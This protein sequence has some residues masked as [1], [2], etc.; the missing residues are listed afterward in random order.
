MMVDIFFS[1][2]SGVH[3]LAVLRLEIDSNSVILRSD[4]AFHHKYLRRLTRDRHQHPQEHEASGSTMC[5][6]R[7]LIPERESRLL[8]HACAGTHLRNR[9]S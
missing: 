5:P 6:N 3:Y 7:L 2:L 8:I 9:S 4:H 1:S